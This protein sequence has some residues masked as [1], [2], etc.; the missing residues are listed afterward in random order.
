M[1]CTHVDAI[2]DPLRTAAEIVDAVVCAIRNHGYTRERAIEDAAEALGLSPRRVKA[3]LHGQAFSMPLSEFQQIRS[4]YR[5]HLD[6][7]VDYHLSQAA[8]ARA[9]AER[10]LAEMGL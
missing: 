6:A 1:P 4:A 3:L 7:Q 10:V 5:A 9:E 8:K 2:P